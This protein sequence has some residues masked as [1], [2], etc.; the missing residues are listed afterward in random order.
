MEVKERVINLLADKLGYEKTEIK[1]THD[2]IMDLNADSLDM[3]EVVMGIEK[4]FGIQIDDN[5]I[6]EIRT[7]GDIIKKVED[8]RLGH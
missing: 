8:I 5:E 7:V 1:E 4:E 3:V 2:I 6:Q